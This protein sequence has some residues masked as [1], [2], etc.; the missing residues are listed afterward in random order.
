MYID[1]GDRR[2]LFIEMVNWLHYEGISC[3]LRGCYFLCT[4]G[5]IGS[6]LQV[7][8]SAIHRLFPL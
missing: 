5:G 8:W 7:I 6:D 4:R 3:S 1:E 2:A